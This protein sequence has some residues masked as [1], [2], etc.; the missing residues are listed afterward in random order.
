[1]VRDLLALARRAAADA[2]PITPNA[3]AWHL[4][5]HAEHARTATAATQEWADAAATWDRL[6]RPPLAAYCRWRQAEALVAAGASRAAAA[7]PLRDAHAV[8]A[9]LGARPL[10]GELELLAQRAR[11]DLAPPGAGS[12]AGKRA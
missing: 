11:L 7:G 12:P 6:E 5:A 3:T 4:Q 2:A 1:R 9:R 8:A 10:A